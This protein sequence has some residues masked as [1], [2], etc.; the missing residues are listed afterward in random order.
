M[1]EL[2]NKPVAVARPSGLGAKHLIRKLFKVRA[3]SNAFGNGGW[4]LVC[5]DEVKR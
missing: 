1:N 3:V 5:E 4:E 2:C